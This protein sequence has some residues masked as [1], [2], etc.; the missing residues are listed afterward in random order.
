[1]ELVATLKLDGRIAVL[2]PL[3]QTGLADML[4]GAKT[5]VHTSEFEGAPRI[6]VEAAACGV[7]LVTCAESDPEGVANMTGGIQCRRD[8][9]SFAIGIEQSIAGPPTNG[10]VT[11]M[12]DRAA[13]KIVPDLEQQILRHLNKQP[14]A[15]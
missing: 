9:A 14:P 12:V 7:R 5:L 8:V 15:I 2:E 3:D 10:G 6:L 4:R 1:L 13:S 11:E